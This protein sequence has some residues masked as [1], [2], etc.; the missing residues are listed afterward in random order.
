MALAENRGSAGQRYTTSV[1]GITAG[2]TFSEPAPRETPAA[3][4]RSGRPHAVADQDPGA[5]RED[6]GSGATTE[7]TGTTHGERAG[8]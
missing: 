7:D 3:A 1:L 8:D 4:G 6:R 2:A 5:P